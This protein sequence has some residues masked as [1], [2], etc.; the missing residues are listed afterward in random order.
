MHFNELTSNFAKK[1]PFSLLSFAGG[2]DLLRGEVKNA[3]GSIAQGAFIPLIAVS[4]FCGP[5]QPQPRFK[6]H[7]TF[8]FKKISEVHQQRKTV[9][10]A[11]IVDFRHIDL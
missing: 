1:I 2:H 10:Q 8:L 11:I 6:S 9:K 7:R 3:I 4:I 5:M